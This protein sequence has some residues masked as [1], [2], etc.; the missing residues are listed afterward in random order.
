M[1]KPPTLT[2]E[3]I[4]ACAH[5][6][7]EANRAYCRALGDLSQPAWDEAPE[8]QRRSAI[9]GVVGVLIDGNGP[10]E[11][12]ES[13]SREKLADG[14]TLGEV[15]D[16]EAKTHPCLVPYDQLPPEQQQKDQLY[17]QTVAAIA[18]ALQGW[19]REEA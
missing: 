11:S 19:R 9:N 15:K 12:H 16:P 1:S 6:A 7:H 3:T 5:A 4:L 14:W 8:W 17:I 13:W 18:T 10:R 2:T